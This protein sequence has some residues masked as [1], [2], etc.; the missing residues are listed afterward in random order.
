MFGMRRVEPGDNGQIIIPEKVIGN[1]S[2]ARAIY[3][4]LRTNNLNRIVLWAEMDGMFAGN[5]PYDP[6][7]VR[8]ANLNIANFNTLEPS[9]WLER[10]ALSYYNLLYTN[11]S[12]INIVLRGDIPELKDISQIISRNW[13][14]VVRDKW[15]SFDINMASLCKQLVKFGVSPMIWNDEHS[16][17]WRMVELNKFLVPDQCQ[18]DLDL[19][20]VVCVENELPVTYLIEVY[21]RYK[22]NPSG[23]HWDI[24][25]LKMLLCFV[26]NNPVKNTY[27]PE[28]A[29]TLQQK[30]TQGDIR[31]D[32]VYNESVPLVSLLY[33]E[34]DGTIS[35]Y[36]FHRYYGIGE[37]NKFIYKFESQ[38]RSFSDFCVIFTQSPGERYIHSNRGLGHKIFALSQAKMMMDTSLLDLARWASTP[39]VK[40][41]PTAIKDADGIRINLGSATNIGGSELMNNSLGANIEPVIAASQYFSGML[42]QNAVFSGDDPG[43]PDRSQQGSLAPTSEKFKALREYGVLRNQVSHFYA[44]CDSLFSE[45]VRRMLHCKRSSPDY[46]VVEEWKRLCVLDGV[47]EEVFATDG[48]GLPKNWEV[49]ATRTAGAGS[50]LG[51]LV[52]LELLTPY[53]GSFGRREQNSFKRDIIKATVGPEYLPAYTQDDNDADELGGGASLAQVENGMMKQGESPLATASNDNRAHVGVH[54]AL[55]REI[56]DLIAQNV[57]DVIQADKIFNVLIPHIQEHIKFLAANIFAQS[58]LEQV[59]KPLEEIIKYA[60]LV[61]GNAMRALEKQADQ[62]QKDQ[63]ETQKVLNEEQRKNLVAEADERRKDFKIASQVERAKEANATRAEVIREKTDNEIVNERR[64]TDAEVQSKLAKSSVNNGAI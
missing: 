59:K 37:S 16:F 27:T 36:M 28:D 49:K 61:R 3:Y 52:S 34:N 2:A 58:F 8:E 50:Q 42:Q 4:Q 13:N 23:T 6:V 57:L 19:L 1:L 20:T 60:A 40:T 54:L 44:I 32:Q 25:E 29:L 64:K 10:G 62:A 22:D 48:K 47:P 30:I 9:A 26:A 63:A 24:E 12:I 53:V 39:I 46:E 38:F 5:P 43:V 18:S 14:S 33:R 56:I 15:K 45:M 31:F 21:N 55:G 51:H 17:K 7:K 41:S 35:H 11:E